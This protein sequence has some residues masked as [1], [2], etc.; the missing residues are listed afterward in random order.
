M[1]IITK[2]NSGYV[3][4]NDEIPLYLKNATELKPEMAN[5]GEGDSSEKFVRVTWGSGFGHWGLIVG[6]INFKDTSHDFSNMLI[7]QW[8]SGVY[9]YLETK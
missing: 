4:P 3:I 9:F 1:S 7:S 8:A 5:L 2:H 6:D